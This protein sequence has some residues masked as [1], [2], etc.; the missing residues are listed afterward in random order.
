MSFSAN[1]LSIQLRNLYFNR[2]PDLYK[3]IRTHASDE[4]LK[5]MHG[6]F[7]MD[8]QPE[9]LNAPKKIMF[10]GMETYGWRKC[11]LNE[12]LQDSYE[13]LIQC[14]QEFMAREKP[15]NSPFWL[16]MRDPQ[17][18]VCVFT[19]RNGYEVCEDTDLGRGQIYFVKNYIGDA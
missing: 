18:L 1:D 19:E 5:N 14:H 11:D 12:D 7:V 2:L 4:Q 16:C 6:P 13:K 15:I 17:P 9:Y 8:V 10:V 3:T